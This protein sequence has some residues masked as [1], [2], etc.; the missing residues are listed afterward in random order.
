MP[1][2]LSSI[3][4]AAALLA[5]TIFFYAVIY[6][7]WLKRRTPQNIVIGGAAGAFPPMIGWAAV[8]GS[9]RSWLDRAVPH[10]LHVDAAA[11]LGAGAVSRKDDYAR[12][13]VPMLPVVAGADET[14]RQILHLQLAG[15]SDLLPAGAARHRRAALCRV[16]SRLLGVAFLWHAVEVYRSGEGDAERRACRRC[17]ASRSL[18]LFAVFALILIE[19]MA[20]LAPFASGLRMSVPAM[21]T[22]P[23]RPGGHG[24]PPQALDR[25]GPGACRPVVL[26]FVTT[27]VR[28]GGNVADRT[29]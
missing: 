25:A 13:G 24:A 8:T 27:I 9:R 11:F 28:L 22:K 15:R 1:R 7:M 23:F 20:G 29:F 6:T 19:R 17:S 14:R 12:A 2:A 26:F 5:F 4:S 21:A 16:A 10:H 18:Y 3:S